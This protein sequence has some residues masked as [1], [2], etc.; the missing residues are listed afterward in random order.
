M[1]GRLDFNIGGASSHPNL[2]K[3]IHTL[4]FLT[5]RGWRDLLAFLNSLIGEMPPNVGPDAPK[6]PPQK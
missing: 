1:Q 4:D 6:T 5:G 2:D 3:E